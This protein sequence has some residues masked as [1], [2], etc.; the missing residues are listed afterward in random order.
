[1]L[2]NEGILLSE[3]ETIN[4][5][6]LGLPL[7]L[8]S[9]Y[10]YSNFPLTNRHNISTQNEIELLSQR[11]SFHVL[12]VLISQRQSTT[13]LLNLS[14][15]LPSMVLKLMTVFHPIS[16]GNFFHMTGIINKLITMEQFKNMILNTMCTP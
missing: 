8:Y 10:E 13:L 16:E 5:T 9:T 6:K 12:Q 3:E 4:H 7:P 2:I 1:M 14:E 15:Q 11:R